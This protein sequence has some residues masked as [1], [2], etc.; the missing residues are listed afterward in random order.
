MEN[1]SRSRCEPRI[2]RTTAGWIRFGK[3]A[4]TD[5][6]SRASPRS[7]QVSAR[8]R[9]GRRTAG[10]SR[11][12]R[13]APA[14]ASAFSC[15]R[16]AVRLAS[17]RVTSRA[18]SRRSRECLRGRRTAARSI[19]SRP[20]HRPPPM[21]NATNCGETSIPMTITASSICGRSRWPTARN[22]ASRAATI[23]SSASKSRRPA[24][25]SPIVRRVPSCSIPT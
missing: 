3:S 25:C 8:R 11:F 10:R 5:R 12:S 19:A 6:R 1:A 24:R 23:R 7:N 2:G 21:Y 15:C 14:P 20:I 9:P 4:R 18:S 22:S 13:A 17:S 16:T